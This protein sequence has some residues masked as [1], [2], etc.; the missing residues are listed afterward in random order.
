MMTNTPTDSER[1][2]ENQAHNQSYS[3][4]NLTEKFR[5][6]GANYQYANDFNA[7]LETSFNASSYL[8]FP[9]QV[10]RPLGTVYLINEGKILENITTKCG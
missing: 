7:N 4:K 10:L 8:G 9:R 1:L 2:T 6:N 3:Y 5:I